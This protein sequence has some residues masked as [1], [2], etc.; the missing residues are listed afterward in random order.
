MTLCPLSLT[1]NAHTRTHTL[2]QDTPHDLH[3][4]LVSSRRAA[5]DAALRELEQRGGAEKRLRAVFAAHYGEM[6]SNCQWFLDDIN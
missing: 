3:T 6:K 2:Y 1:H 4:G 5:V